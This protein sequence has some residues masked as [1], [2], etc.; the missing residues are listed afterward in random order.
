[1]KDIGNNYKLYIKTVLPRLSA[2]ARN[3]R[4]IALL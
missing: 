3:L 2:G 1:M 4:L